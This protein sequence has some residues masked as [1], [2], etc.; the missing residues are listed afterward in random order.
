[1]VQSLL[2]LVANEMAANE[3]CKNDRELQ[4]F[5]KN[6]KD[7]IAAQKKKEGVIGEKYAGLKP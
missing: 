5:Y 1:M 4:A 3:A 7:H 6:T 2:D